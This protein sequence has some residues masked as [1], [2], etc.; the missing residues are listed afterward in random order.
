MTERAPRTTTLHVP[1][2]ATAAPLFLRP[3][4]ERDLEPLVEAHRDPVLRRWTRTPVTDHAD[5]VHWLQTQARGWS[6]GDSLSFA[7]F[8]RPGAGSADAG[9]RQE[10][11]ASLGERFV[12]HVV[13]KRADPT[14]PTAEVGY[15]TAAAA[16]GRGVAPRAL[17]ALTT[18]AFRTL[19]GLDRLELL[20]QVDNIA[21]CRVAE[22]SGYG[23]EATLPAYPPYPTDG[24]LH[25]RTD[26][27]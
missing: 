26:R 15:W 2:T 6:A 23:Y 21:S 11:P 9:T 12:A 13:L 24:H 3:W 14:G 17:E 10:V 22:K 20:H 7:V 18:W 25:V 19:G 1:A 8:E 4:T 16:R 5:A 27:R